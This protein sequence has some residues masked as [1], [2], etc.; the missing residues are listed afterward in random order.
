MRPAAACAV[1]GT[2]AVVASMVG[3]NIWIGYVGLAMVIGALLSLA[4]EDP[5]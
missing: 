2:V 1:L 4:G 5:P 3:G